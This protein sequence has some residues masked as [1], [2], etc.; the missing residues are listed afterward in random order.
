MKAEV[1]GYKEY[2][3][4]KCGWV[5]AAISM[6]AVPRGQTLDRYLR[7]FN[8]GIL[9]FNFV[10]AEPEDAPDGCTLQP[11]VIPGVWE[12]FLT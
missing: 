1:L 4:N 7:C 3:C 2:K 5:H 8:C 10:P 11:V 6:H 9:A 12:E